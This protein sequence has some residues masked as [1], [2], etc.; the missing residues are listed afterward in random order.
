MACQFA[1]TCLPVSVPSGT[2]PLPRRGGLARLADLQHCLACSS[3]EASSQSCRVPG[4]VTLMLGYLGRR[5]G[6]RLEVRKG[7]WL[8]EQA[9]ESSL[10]SQGHGVLD[11]RTSG[12]SS[13]GQL[14]LLSIWS[15]HTFYLTRLNPPVHRRTASARLVCPPVFL[16]CHTYLANSL[17]SNSVEPSKPR[18]DLHSLIFSVL[19]PRDYGKHLLN[20]SWAEPFDDWGMGSGGALD[21]LD[22]QGVGSRC[23]HSPVMLL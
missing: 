17:K 3:L 13:A 15:Q 7:W 8:P 14:W 9:I 12:A 16:Y 18:L 10:E 2:A 6:V 19:F 1:Q 20:S 4:E 21:D 11:V 5:V 23:P 22:M